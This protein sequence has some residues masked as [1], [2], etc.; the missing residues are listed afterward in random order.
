MN[1]ILPVDA[2]MAG[3]DDQR[4]VSFLAH[5]SGPI[6]ARALPTIGARI[7]SVPLLKEELFAAAADPANLALTLYAFVKV[8][9]IAGMTV[10]DYGTAE[11]IARLKQV[12]SAWPDSERKGFLAYVKDYRDFDKVMQHV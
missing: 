6:R 3:L 9:W 8:A 7:A 5:A 4:L 10:L 11:D 2:Q 1:T 12:V